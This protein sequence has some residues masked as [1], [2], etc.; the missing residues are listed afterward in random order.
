MPGALSLSKNFR[1]LNRRVQSPSLGENE[2]PDTTDCAPSGRR[3]GTVGARGG[4]T[5]IDS[6]PANLLGCGVNSQGARV[7]ASADG[8]WATNYTPTIATI[9]RTLTT[10]TVTF[11]NIHGFNVND[12]ALIT[13]DSTDPDYSAVSALEGIYVVTAVSPTTITY[14]HGVSGTIAST[15]ISGSAYFSGMDTS[16]KVRFL[17]F[18]RLLYAFNGRNRMRLTAGGGFILSGIDRVVFTPSVTPSATGISGTYRYYVVPA[19]QAIGDIQG[20]PMEGLEST[21]SPEITVTNKTITVGNIP[22]THANKAVQGWNVY[23]NL[24]GSY[25]YFYYIG[26]V[27]IGTTTY[28]DTKSDNNINPAVESTL[29]F[30][31]QNTPPTA[32][33]GVMF[34]NRMFL[35]GFD[36]YVTGTA[37][38]NAD[39]TKV[40]FSGAS[41]PDGFKGCYFQLQ[42]DSA[43]Y[44]VKNVLSTTQVELTAAFTTTYT[45]T[46]AGAGYRIF[47]QY[48]EINF[49]EW[50]DPNAWGRDGELYRNKRWIPEGE[51][52]TGLAAFQGNLLVFTGV[53]IYVIQGQG[54][55]NDDI[56]ILPDPLFK[57]FGCVSHD[58][59][60]HV[61]NELHWLSWR[62]P[63]SIRNGAPEETGAV[64]N[65]DWIDTITATNM[66]LA[67]AGTDDKNIWFSWPS[68]ETAGGTAYNGRTVRFERDTQTWWEET[69]IHPTMYVRVNGTDERLDVC[70]Y[71]QGKYL[72][73]PNFGGFDGTPSPFSGVIGVPISSVGCTIT[74]AANVMTVDMTGAHY[75]TTGDTIAFTSSAY[76]LANGN[77]VVTVIDSD[78]F[79]FPL[80]AGNDSAPSDVTISIVT[81]TST[82]SFKANLDIG[83]S[84]FEQLYVRI[85]RAGVLIG[86]RLIISG[87]TTS[88]T[89]S[90]NAA[91]PGTGALTIRPGDTWEVGNIWWKWK[92]RDV[93]D[94]LQLL[95]VRDMAFMFD[96]TSD[97]IQ[98]QVTQFVNGVER[99]NGARSTITLKTLTQKLGSMTT[100]RSFA[101]RIE[102]RNYAVLQEVGLVMS[103]EKSNK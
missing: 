8:T 43:I 72:F 35:A 50:G 33:Y 97:T 82:S 30:D 20:R 63:V 62:G 7:L 65:T 92:T 14:T 31:T 100:A 101:L 4:R 67:C 88:V 12:S 52:I 58:T 15:T 70:H 71:L 96:V 55:N 89:W 19:M 32:K 18:G 77:R 87:T 24:S 90:T 79:S 3:V 53:A 23:R 68:T 9:S 64:L 78:S 5:R 46:F 75:L 95:K 13:L 66:A 103:A 84:N 51:K 1:G 38:L 83:A 17:S 36:D 99:T 61:D 59:I 60:V 69:E 42:G 45:G 93:D 40:D 28:V 29:R 85:F 80:V 39:T 2:S 98:A 44:V 73:R 34:G 48:N 22:A 16:A 86:S 49:S 47:R 6:R 74:I 21:V 27:A 56:R 26:S 37:T 91:L 25:D 76:P 94:V 10:V 81:F 41:I 11:S 102:S 54:T 57:G